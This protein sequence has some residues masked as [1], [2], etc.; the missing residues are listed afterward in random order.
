MLLSSVSG[1]KATSKTRFSDRTSESWG[2]KSSVQGTSP[3]YLDL[4][5]HLYEVREVAVAAGGLAG[6]EAGREGVGEEPWVA[7]HDDGEI[8]SISALSVV[9]S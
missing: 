1:W 5:T 9:V 3:R 6:G 2:N 7:V 4:S 8:S